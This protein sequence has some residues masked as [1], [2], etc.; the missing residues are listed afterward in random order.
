MTSANELI[1]NFVLNSTWQIVAIFVLAAVGTYLLKNCSAHYRYVVWITA[2]FLCLIAPVITAPN[3][4]V[5]C[6]FIRS[7]NPC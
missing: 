2:L 3:V 4:A 7:S 5:S 6:S 1:F